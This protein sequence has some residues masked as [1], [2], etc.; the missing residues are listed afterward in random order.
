MKTHLKKFVRGYLL[1]GSLYMFVEAIIHFSNIKLSSVST[2][3]PKEALTFSSLMS[4][5][6]GSTTLF[7]A[8]IQL[9]VQTNIEKFKKIIQLLAFYAGFHGILLIFIS[10][11]NEVDS[12][13]N[14]YPSLLFWIP[15]YNYYLL[16]EAGLLLLFALLIYFWSRLK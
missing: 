7:L 3:W 5:F 9:L 2:N 16:F 1:F 4:S 8:A 14:N 11:T 10:A 15:F 12:I 6:Y 13:Y